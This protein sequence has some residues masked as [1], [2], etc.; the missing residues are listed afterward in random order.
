MTCLDFFFRHES[1]QKKFTT[2]P[3][4][5]NFLVSL[6]KSNCIAKSTYW[7]CSYLYFFRWWTALGWLEN[8]YVFV[9]SLLF[10]CCKTA[11]P[12]IFNTLVKYSAHKTIDKCLLHFYI[13][14][15]NHENGEK[16]RKNSLNSVS[17]RPK[18]LWQLVAKLRLIPTRSTGDQAKWDIFDRWIRCKKWSAITVNGKRLR[19]FAPFLNWSDQLYF[20]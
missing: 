11:A 13:T 3:N 5:L 17:R 9:G 18:H 20:S 15:K 19:L 16:T 6:H 1:W 14:L 10:C 8:V 7:S 4:I 2:I 12:V